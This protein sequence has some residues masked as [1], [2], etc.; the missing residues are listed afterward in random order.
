MDSG[1]KLLLTFSVLAV[2]LAA[3]TQVAEETHPIPPGEKLFFEG[4]MGGQ[5]FHEYVH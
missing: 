3:W 1:V 5:A 2:A 4:T